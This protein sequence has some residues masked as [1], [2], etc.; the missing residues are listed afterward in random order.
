MKENYVL[1]DRYCYTGYV[2]STN[3]LIQKISNRFIKPDVVF[4][5]SAKPSTLKARVKARKSEK[6]NYYNEEDVKQQIKKFDFLAKKCNFEIIDTEKSLAENI[7]KLH[8]ILN[9]LL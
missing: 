3:N 9:K 6:Y 5:S 4:L 2:R 8:E 1:C 7:K